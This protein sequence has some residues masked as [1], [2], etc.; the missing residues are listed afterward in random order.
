MVSAP[1]WYGPIPSSPDQTGGED[2]VMRAGNR[3]STSQQPNDDF[4]QGPLLFGFVCFCSCND[5]L[6]S[7]NLMGAL[8]STAA[9]ESHFFLQKS[10]CK[11][12]TGEGGEEGGDRDFKKYAFKELI[13]LLAPMLKGKW[14][15]LTSQRRTW[16]SPLPKG[17]SL[18]VSTWK[19]RL[20]LLPKRNVRSFMWQSWLRLYRACWAGSPHQ[21]L[22]GFSPTVGRWLRVLASSP[23]ASCLSMPSHLCFNIMYVHGEFSDRLLPTCQSLPSCLYIC[24]LS[25]AHDWGQSVKHR[26]TFAFSF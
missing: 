10:P 12:G 11:A 8:S 2:P 13:K 1:S 7:T 18:L 9:F 5:A 15:P 24:L 3:L 14:V 4:M 23:L 6:K 19:E 20:R 16:S 22:R 25:P 21:E 17:K 26:S